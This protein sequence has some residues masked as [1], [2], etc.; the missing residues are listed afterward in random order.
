MPS[1][2]PPLGHPVADVQN[3]IYLPQKKGVSGWGGGSRLPFEFSTR[4][5]TVKSSESCKYRVIF[6]F[7]ITPETGRGVLIKSANREFSG[8]LSPAH[9]ILSLV[10]NGGAAAGPQADGLDVC[11][12]S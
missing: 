8:L 10:K 7:K 1:H 11:C 2:Y 5:H 9:S 6:C 3:S 12:R 4:I